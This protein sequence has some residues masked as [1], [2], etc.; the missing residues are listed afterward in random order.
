MMFSLKNFSNDVLAGN[1]V[2]KFRGDDC[3]FRGDDY[4]DPECTQYI[5]PGNLKY[6]MEYYLDK[7]ISIHKHLALSFNSVLIQHIESTDI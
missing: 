4:C 5:R 7:K 3:E 6:M 2:G 1:C